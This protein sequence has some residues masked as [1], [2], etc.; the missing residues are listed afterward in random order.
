MSGRGKL[1]AAGTKTLNRL[2]DFFRALGL[3]SDFEL[4][5][6]VVFEAVLEHER[7]PGRAASSATWQ[8]SLPP[9]MLATRST[10]DLL[11]TDAT[12]AAR[13]RSAHVLAATVIHL[14]HHRRSSMSKYVAGEDS[15]LPVPRHI[16]SRRIQQ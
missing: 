9:V 2:F 10:R 8:R 5:P 14:M 4:R 3:T 11:S 12:Y 15:T 16:R 1:A 6:R 7:G 13:P